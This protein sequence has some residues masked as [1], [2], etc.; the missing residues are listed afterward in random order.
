MV[1]LAWPF[2]WLFPDLARMAPL[3]V[4][5]DELLGERRNGVDGFKGKL[6]Y[7]HYNIDDVEDAV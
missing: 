4:C 6:T 7:W 3:T 1:C 2:S 5:C